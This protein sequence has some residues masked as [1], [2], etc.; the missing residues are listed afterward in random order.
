MS[1]K[2]I[3]PCIISVL[4]LVL[5]IGGGYFLYQNIQ[6]LK[7]EITTLTDESYSLES[8][9]NRLLSLRKVAQS[10][11]DDLQKLN[12]FFVQKDGA[13][14]FVE[15]IEFLAK[16]S[17]LQYK[18]EFF[19]VEKNDE[20]QERGRELLRT[21]IRVTGTQQNTR[22]FLSLIE[23]LPYNTHIA[24]VDM[25]KTS[26]PAV[27]IKASAVPEK[28]EWSTLI[29]FSVIKIAESV[30]ENVPESASEGQ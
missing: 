15:Y 30:Q 25:R 10:T 3:I 7:E 21:S 29:D 6:S 2:H 14:L 28:N 12:S 4:I 9:S 19:D 18:I 11:G 1:K 8:Q 27:G 22:Y 16:E 23:S 24:R 17:R 5:F 26:I 13:L 20:L